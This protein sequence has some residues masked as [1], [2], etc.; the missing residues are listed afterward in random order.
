METKWGPEF[1]WVRWEMAEMVVLEYSG[2]W[3]AWWEGTG[4][5]PVSHRAE[6]PYLLIQVPLRLC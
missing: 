2:D 6:F 1:G 4:E 5:V 3:L